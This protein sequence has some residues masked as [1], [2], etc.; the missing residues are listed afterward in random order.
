MFLLCLSLLYNELYL[1][2]ISKCYCVK[3][4]HSLFSIVSSQLTITTALL[5]NVL[6]ISAILL[7]CSTDI[8]QILSE[9]VL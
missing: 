3:L 5:L 2:I 1:L 7:T 9:D 6:I 8:K 4:N